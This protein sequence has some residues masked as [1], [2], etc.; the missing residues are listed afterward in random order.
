MNKQFKQKQSRFAP[1]AIKKM[2]I[3]IG[4]SISKATSLDANTVVS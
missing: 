2:F 1:S 4:M 3:P